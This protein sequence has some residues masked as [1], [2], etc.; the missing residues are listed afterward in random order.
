[1]KP[2]RIIRGLPSRKRYLRCAQRSYSSLANFVCSCII[3]EVGSPPN[4]G[5]KFQTSSESGK[6]GESKKEDLCNQLHF[7]S[8]V[9]A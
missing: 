1:M 2:T 8:V 7:A 9:G 3:E 5:P 6:A 4:P